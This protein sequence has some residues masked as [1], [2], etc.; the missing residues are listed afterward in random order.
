M[1][2]VSYQRL[3]RNNY[4]RS[5]MRS[6]FPRKFTRYYT[7]DICTGKTQ[8][9]AEMRFLHFP[10]SFNQIQSISFLICYA[11]FTHNTRTYPFILRFGIS[12]KSRLLDILCTYRLIPLTKN[13]NIWILPI[14]L[15]VSSSWMMYIW[16]YTYFLVWTHMVEVLLSFVPHWLAVTTL[17][18]LVCRKQRE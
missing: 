4:K 10:R 5:R 14:Y 16:Q 9:S 17:N 8:N 7:I 11:L 12:R 6:Y 1:G 3:R 15:C 2:I 18:V 13:I